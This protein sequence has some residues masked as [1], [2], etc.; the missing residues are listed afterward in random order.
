MTQTTA[1]LYVSAGWK[2]EKNRQMEYITQ[3]KISR[4]FFGNARVCIPEWLE[5]EQ[6]ILEKEMGGTP[7]CVLFATWI[8]FMVNFVSWISTLV[9]VLEDKLSNVLNHRQWT[10]FCSFVRFSWKFL[11]LFPVKKCSIFQGQFTVC[12]LIPTS[13]IEAFAWASRFINEEMQMKLN[14]P[15]IG[16]FSK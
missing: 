5:L 12:S 15:Y 8:Y 2:S 16:M 3:A 6:N 1:L 7:W 11:C 13:Y 4:R 9:H 14:Q 10:R